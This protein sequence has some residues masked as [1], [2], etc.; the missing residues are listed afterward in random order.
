MPLRRRIRTLMIY[1]IIIILTD[2]PHQHRSVWSS[3]AKC[4]AWTL[5]SRP[6]VVSSVQRA[7]K[8]RLDPLGEARD[9]RCGAFLWR[10][11]SRRPWK[12]IKLKYFTI[13]WRVAF[14]AHLLCYIIYDFPFSLA[15]LNH[16]YFFVFSRWEGN[17]IV[18]CSIS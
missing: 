12:M 1:W 13:C 6:M 14:V 8:S 17:V 9:L 11:V 18:I 10:S 16:F 2:K 3:Q 15:F 7:W 4:S 5:M